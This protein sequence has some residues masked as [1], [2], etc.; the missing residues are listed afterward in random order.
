VIQELGGSGNPLASYA[1]GPGVDE[2]L[3]LYSGP[4][5]SYC[6][7]DGL[8]SLTALTDPTGAVAASYVYDSFGNLTASTGTITNAYRYTAR[9][10]DSETG[11]YYYRAR[12]YDP[13]TGRF[14][15]EDPDKSSSPQSLYPYA[16]NSPV[17]LT[18]ALGMQVQ[19]PVLV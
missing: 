5:T 15:T 4:T 14:A 19:S 16:D 12:Y 2:P 10:F 7:A 17:R 1:H 6:H 3:A 9:E 11:L 18:D 13:A 8:G